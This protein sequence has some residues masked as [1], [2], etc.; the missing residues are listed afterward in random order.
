[1]LALSLALALALTAT[2]YGGSVPC[3]RVIVPAVV[4]VLIRTLSMTFSRR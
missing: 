1:V 3:C 4:V 2:C